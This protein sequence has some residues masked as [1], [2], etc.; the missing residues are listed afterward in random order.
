VDV[1]R[2]VESRDG[3]I[4]LYRPRKLVRPAPAESFVREAVA[5]AGFL[6]SS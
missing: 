3:V 4:F 5:A 2:V 1:P 6:A